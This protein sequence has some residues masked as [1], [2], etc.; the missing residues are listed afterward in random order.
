MNERERERKRGN[1]KFRWIEVA[2]YDLQHKESIVRSH[3]KLLLFFYFW[4]NSFLLFFRSF[5]IN[6]HRHTICNSSIDAK[7]LVCVSKSKS[8]KYRYDTIKYDCVGYL[9]DSM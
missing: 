2:I 5:S 6:T 7:A 4:N 9:L 1:S 3:N 8:S